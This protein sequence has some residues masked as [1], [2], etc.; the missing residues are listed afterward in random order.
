MGH[1]EE[2]KNVQDILHVQSVPRSHGHAW[3]QRARQSFTYRC[4]AQ[5]TVEA[6]KRFCEPTCGPF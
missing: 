1:C 6:A 5:Q 4:T 2:Q 3:L